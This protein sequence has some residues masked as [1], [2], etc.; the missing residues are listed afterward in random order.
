MFEFVYFVLK[1]KNVSKCNF[2][3]FLSVFYLYI[4]TT[5]MYVVFC[6]VVVHNLVHNTPNNVCN[7]T[8]RTC[9]ES[10]ACAFALARSL[11]TSL[12]LD[13]DVFIIIQMSFC[14][15]LN[16]ISCILWLLLLPDV[17]LYM[18]NDALFFWYTQHCA[19]YTTSCKANSHHNKFMHARAQWELCE[20][21][22]YVCGGGGAE[23]RSFVVGGFIFSIILVQMV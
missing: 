14:I 19:P 9:T 1:L 7:T 22:Y 12:L 8:I 6:D 5:P 13:F 20:Y 23:T 16:W 15:N 18:L 10:W 17:L 4:H 21:I 2:N 11:A 3:F